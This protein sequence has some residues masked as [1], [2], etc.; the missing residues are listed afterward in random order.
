[1][2]CCLHTELAWFAHLGAL[3]AVDFF[4]RAGCV[5]GGVAQID[6]LLGHFQSQTGSQYSGS[7]MQ[8]E[9]MAQMVSSKLGFN[10][11]PSLLQKL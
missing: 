1:M 8:A 9:M 3:C 4:W 11:P 6:S 7:G 10:V 2:F 5:G